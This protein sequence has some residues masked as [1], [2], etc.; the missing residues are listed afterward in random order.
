M[1]S[2]WEPN[3]GGTHA[4]DEEEKEK[5]YCFEKT[6]EYCSKMKYE[7]HHWG[8]KSYGNKHGQLVISS[9]ASSSERFMGNVTHVKRHGKA[10][11]ARTARAWSPRSLWDLRKFYQKKWEGNALTF[12]WFFK[13]MRI[14]I[15]MYQLISWFEDHDWGEVINIRQVAQSHQNRISRSPI[16][17]AWC[18]CSQ[19]QSNK[20]T[21]WSKQKPSFVK[22][23][24]YIMFSLGTIH[25]AFRAA[26]G[27][28]F[29]CKHLR[30]GKTHD[31]V[32]ID[33]LLQDDRNWT[34]FSS[35]AICS[36][37]IVQK[38]DHTSDEATWPY[39]IR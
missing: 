4:G 39:V 32:Y 35:N 7:F 8:T 12:Q 1:A 16:C 15:F 18:W 9:D 23:M 31:L 34:F 10:K 17:C 14:R 30:M 2:A 5:W 21:L 29:S 37:S 11:P 13:A 38:S 22:G 3:V 27:E 33:L 6:N 25:P 26:I 36:S 28:Q 20:S 24:V 19:R